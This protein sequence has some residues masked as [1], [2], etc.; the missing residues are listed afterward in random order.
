MVTMEG[1]LSIDK[2]NLREAAGAISLEDIAQLVEWLALKDDAVRY[3]A[4][5]LLENRSGCSADVYSYWEVFRA[6]L[7]SENSYQR[8]I[9]LML[10]AANAGWDTEGKMDDSLGEYLTLLNDE[11]SITVR[12]C[13]Q[14]LGRIAVCKPGLGGEIAARLIS[15]DL[16]A[17]KETMRKLLLQDILNVLLVI[18]KGRT[19]DEIE[20]F[21]LKAL[22][23]ELLDRKAKKQI[24][25][26]L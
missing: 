2:E 6:K 21:I 1:I 7:K 17:A 26:L 25:A 15:L 9:G 13:I 23:G 8:S 19:S 16:A 18:R 4:F 12:Q 14:S 24:E 11:K 22:S 5:L 20:S 10:L 3:R